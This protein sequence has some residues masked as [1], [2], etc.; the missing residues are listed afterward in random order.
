MAHAFADFN[1][2]GLLDLLVTGMHCPTALRLEHLGAARPGY[3]DYARFRGAMTA[4]NRLWIAQPTAGFASDPLNVSL[5]NSGWSWG[6]TA[7]DVDNDGWPD[8]YVANGHET[9]QSVRDYEPEFWLHDIY[10]GRSDEDLMRTAYFGAKI[11]RT[12]GRGWSYGGYE[13][14]RLFLNRSGAEFIE[15]GH[16][17]GVG[18]Q[19][20]C[21]AAVA[22]DLDGDGRV[23]LLVTSFEVWPKVK[24]TIR[25]YRNQLHPSGNW[26]GF[27]L[28]PRPGQPW[29]VGTRVTIQTANQRSVRQVVTGDSHRAQHSLTVHFGLGRADHV[30]RVTITWPDRR[31][32]ELKQPEINRYHGVSA[33]GAE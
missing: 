16:L 4:G 28:Q 8:V 30:E 5:S 11:A 10:V 29:P 26:I 7:P 24:Q 9:R 14:N 2:D 17:F 21:R 19:R 20:D 31:V 1:R 3:D 32:V 27:R 22:D 12:R 25:A 6:C 15:I 13:M 18:E 23:D 33:V